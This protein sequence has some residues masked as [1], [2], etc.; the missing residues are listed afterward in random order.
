MNRCRY[1]RNLLLDQQSIKIVFDGNCCWW[2]IEKGNDCQNP[3]YHPSETPTICDRMPC[4]SLNSDGCTLCSY[5]GCLPPPITTTIG[6]FINTL[7][8]QTYQKCQFER[9]KM[10]ENISAKQNRISYFL[11]QCF[12]KIDKFHEKWETSDCEVT[13]YYSPNH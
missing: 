6:I 4:K 9:N 5:V 2:K 11:L 8:W 1:F 7:K 3:N 12:C 13:I 10:L